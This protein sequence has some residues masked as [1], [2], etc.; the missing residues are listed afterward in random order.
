MFTLRSGI[1]VAR[2]D[3]RSAV[4]RAVASSVDPISTPPKPAA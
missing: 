2:Y 3:A 4:V 1:C